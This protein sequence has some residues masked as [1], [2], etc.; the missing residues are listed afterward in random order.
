[1]AEDHTIIV[2]SPSRGSGATWIIALVLIVA[3]IAGLLFFSSMSNS[4][5]SKNNAVT[6]AAQDV[7]QA[8][9]NVGDAAQDTANGG[10]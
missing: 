10:K 9:K 8:A 5:V 4:E 6:S 1:M 2:E 3:L 7:G